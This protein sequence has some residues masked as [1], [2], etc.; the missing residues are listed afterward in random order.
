MPRV[1]PRTHQ[2]CIHC[3]RSPAGFWVTGKSCT[4]VRRPW[5]LAC[6]QDLDRARCDVTP[7]AS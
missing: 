1:P 4:V 2:V 6:C 3:R 5:C 7:F